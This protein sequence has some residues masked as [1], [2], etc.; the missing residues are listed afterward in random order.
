MAKYLITGGAGFIGSNIAE[1]LIKAGQ[2][3]AILDD[4]SSGKMEN[5]TSFKKNINLYTGDIRNSNTVHNA[6]NGVDFVLHHAAIPSVQL[7]V[8]QPVLIHDVNVN[9]TLNVLECCRN[10]KIKRFVLASSCSVYGDSAIPPLKETLPA[11]PLSPYALSKLIGEYYCKIYKELYGLNT[12]ALRYFNVYGPR[13]DSQSDYGAVIP[14]FITALLKNETPVI[15]GS[16]KQTRDFVFVEDVFNANMKACNAEDKICG[17]IYNIARGTEVSI[18]DLLDAVKQA[19]GS[20]IETRYMKKRDGEV[21]RS[22][23][24]INKTSELLDF[25]AK[26][27]LDEGIQKTVNWFRK[28][29]G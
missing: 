29:N 26:F 8:E 22:C 14:K 16:G 21:D 12:V 15:Y 3:V 5:I 6:L 4:F 17:Q 1:R 20:S 27:G 9:G 13:Q 10:A 23:S 7:S 18:N 11:N 24:D 28:N 19:T 25:K 2:E